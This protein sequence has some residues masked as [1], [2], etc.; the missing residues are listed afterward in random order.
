M[1]DSAAL[2]FLLNSE[3]ALPVPATGSRD[4]V[5]AARQTG[6][7]ETAIHI[8]RLDRDQKTVCSARGSVAR[9]LTQFSNSSRQSHDKRAHFHSFEGLPISLEF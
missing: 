6:R 2:R 9:S 3:S 1:G 4:L 8:T 5:T 7:A